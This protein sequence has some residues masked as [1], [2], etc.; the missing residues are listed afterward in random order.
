MDQPSGNEIASICIVSDVLYQKWKFDFLK[1]CVSEAVGSPHSPVSLG[2][3]VIEK[4]PVGI[5]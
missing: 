1:T 4:S 2:A 3:Y 5:L